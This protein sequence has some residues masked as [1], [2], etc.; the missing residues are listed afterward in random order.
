MG[1]WKN[2]G[3]SVAFD[4]VIAADGTITDAGDDP[5]ADLI[6]VCNPN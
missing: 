3:L 6:I 2:M 5:I 4:G 1:A